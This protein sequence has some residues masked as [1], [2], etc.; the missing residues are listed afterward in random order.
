[1]E[2]TPYAPPGSDLYYTLRKLPPALR[3]RY[4]G[5]AAL[6]RE[7]NRTAEE[8]REVSV[9]E[10]K[11][12]WWH[13]DI[14]RFFKG[15][16][17]HPIL[18]SLMPWQSSLSQ[19]AMLALVEA[20]ALS[21]KTH[22]FETRSELFQHYQHLGGIKFDLIWPSPM[23]ESREETQARHLLGIR[24]E[25]LRHLIHFK[26]FLGRQ[27]LYFAMEDFQAHGIDPKPILQLK[28]LHT[29]WPLFNE[30]FELPS[31]LSSPDSLS[32]PRKRESRPLRMQVLLKHKQAALMQKDHWQFSTHQIE[33][34][35]LM[36]LFLTTFSR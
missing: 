3:G 19:T 29:L 24:D 23:R 2:L 22:I 17:S 10:K 8:Y 28:Q 31:E 32:F 36:K 7:L 12:V 5:I 30:Y 11:L 4:L 25:V 1:M 34:S 14:E 16:A 13:E 20:N 27:H 26:T 6:A 15:E 9:A 21:L 33:L 35:P 18:Q